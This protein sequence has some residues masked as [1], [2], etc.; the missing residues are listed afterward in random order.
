MTGQPP[1]AH[2]AFKQFEREKFSLVA[3]GYDQA[4]AQV[5]SQVDQ[6]ILDAVEAG[7]GKQLLDVACGTGWL[8]AA[9]VS[10]QAIVTGLDYADDMVAIARLRCPEAEFQI[11]D[12]ENLPFESSRF[13]AVVC[14]LG[15]LHFPNP[16]RVIASSFRV[17]KPGGRYAFTCWTPPERNPFMNLILGSVQTYGNME[18]DLPPG[19]PLFRF[20]ETAEC[21][22][23]L[24]SGGFTSVSITELP[25]K[26]TF[27]TPQDVMPRIVVSTARLG[28]I[29]AMQT[30]EQR[31]NIENAIIER[32]KKYVTDDGLEIPAS[33]VLA[34]GHKP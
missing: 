33:V 26:W 2:E 6:A 21:K 18:I 7:Y 23:V 34:V 9:A 8:S 27:S 14:S 25:M 16:E 4:I 10:R 17:L 29:L 15:I 20:G 12:A 22:R 11:G 19:P 28:S 24:S 31:R 30:E 13:D 1:I 5:T 3:Q 32:A